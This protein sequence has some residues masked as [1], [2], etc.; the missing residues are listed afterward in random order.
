MRQTDACVL[1]LNIQNYLTTIL[2]KRN[3]ICNHRVN[4]QSPH[5][6]NVSHEQPTIRSTTHTHTHTLHH[7]Q[8]STGA[9]N[10]AK[11]RLPERAV[12]ATLSLTTSH[13]HKTYNWVNGRKVIKVIYNCD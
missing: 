4:K 12:I 8:Q 2:T 5:Q 11:P 10:T 6:P 13:K 9:V 1:Q 3:K 7:I